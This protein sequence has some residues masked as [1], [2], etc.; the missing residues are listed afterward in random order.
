VNCQKNK[1]TY[2]IFILQYFVKRR[3]L[4]Y[5]TFLQVNGKYI[6]KSGTD[7][8]N[9][10]KITLTFGLNGT[11]VDIQRVDLDSSIPEDPEMKKIVSHLNG[12]YL[13][14]T[15]YCSINFNF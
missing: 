8:R 12:R 3:Y 5:V 11:K 10:S 15:K 6:I 1:E 14:F 9:L 13:L 4:P 2:H 7:F